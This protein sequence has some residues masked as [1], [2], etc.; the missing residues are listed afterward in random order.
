MNDKTYS[1]NIYNEFESES[2][3]EDSFRDNSDEDSDSVPQLSDLENDPSQ[4]NCNPLAK[5]KEK[6]KIKVKDKTSN[7]RLKN[8]SGWVDVKSKKPSDLELEHKNRKE[9][10]IT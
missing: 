2:S 5:P 9:K 6:R 3:E 8:V 7:K 4:S 1:R 10:T